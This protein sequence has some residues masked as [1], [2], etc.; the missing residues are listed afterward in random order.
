MDNS[1]I[2]NVVEEISDA[3]EDGFN[4]DLVLSFEDGHLEGIRRE[5][6]IGESYTKRLN[7]KTEKEL[8]AEIVI[9][10]KSIKNYSG[11]FLAALDK[12]SKEERNRE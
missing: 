11:A 5:E 9:Y 1:K 4:G 8:I 2:D 10:M 7:I 6:G 3:M 12:S